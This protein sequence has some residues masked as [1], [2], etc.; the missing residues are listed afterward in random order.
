MSK[1]GVFFHGRPQGQKF[2]SNGDLTK[3]DSS[4]L[5]P[6][7]DSKIGADSSSAMIIDYVKG[8]AYYSFVVRK[9]VIEK[10]RGTESYFAISLKIEKGYCKN[11]TKLYSLLSLVYAEKCEN[12]LFAKENNGMRRFRI[13]SFDEIDSVLSEARNILISNFDKVITQYVHPLNVGADTSRSNNVTKYSLK[14]ADSAIFFEDCA[15]CKVVV[16]ADYPR[17]DIGLQQE[18]KKLEQEK[19]RAREESEK[20]ATQLQNQLTDKQHEL[21]R[22]VQQGNTLTVKVSELQSK[23]DSLKTAEEEIKRWK[24]E[25]EDYKSQYN[26]KK[27]DCDKAEQEVSNL[28]QQLKKKS[29]ASNDR[30]LDTDRPM[31]GR[32]QGGPEIGYANC[33]KYYQNDNEKVWP[34]WLVLVTFSLLLVATLISATFSVLTYFRSSASLKAIIQEQKQENVLPDIQM[35]KPEPHAICNLKQEEQGYKIDIAGNQS[36]WKLDILQQCH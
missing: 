18:I 33:P 16:S 24:K 21:D 19:V 1:V 6:F 34:N 8:N 23:L 13:N 36:E 2:W 7:L 11:V 5:E 26:N 3:E 20:K 31:A 10:E 22:A 30:T 14:E 9:N 28:R 27:K 12:A 4:Y 32:F 25:A 29:N 35:Q 17:R 15:T